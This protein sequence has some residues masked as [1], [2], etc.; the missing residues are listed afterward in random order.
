[1]NRLSL[2]KPDALF[3]IVLLWIL[4]RAES[5]HLLKVTMRPRTQSQLTRTPDISPADMHSVDKMA[6]VLLKVEF[7]LIILK[8]TLSLTYEGRSKSS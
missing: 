6:A 5:S 2:T 1:M 4:C 3:I 8:W 7:P